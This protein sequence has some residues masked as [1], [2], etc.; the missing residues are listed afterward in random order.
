MESSGSL[1]PSGRSNGMFVKFRLVVFVPW[2]ATGTARVR[3]KAIVIVVIARFILFS[4]LLSIIVTLQVFPGRFP[5]D[6][7]ANMSCRRYLAEDQTLSSKN[8]ADLSFE[9]RET[10]FFLRHRY[11]KNQQDASSNDS[12]EVNVD[13]RFG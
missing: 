10:R 9:S 5:F 6:V 1:L 7:D 11:E 4:S 12:G 2:A 13:A 8:C 3:I